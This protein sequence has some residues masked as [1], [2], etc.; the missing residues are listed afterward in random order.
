MTINGAKSG[1]R[2]PYGAAQLTIDQNNKFRRVAAKQLSARGIYLDIGGPFAS[3]TWAISNPRR[4]DV[5]W[6][7]TEKYHGYAHPHL[8]F[9]DWANKITNGTMTT[10][11]TGSLVT[12]SQLLGYGATGI[13]RTLPT[14]PEMSISTSI[15]ELTEGL[16]S[17]IG[18]QLKRGPSAHAVGG[19]Y[20]NYQ[21]GIAPMIS[22]V[23]D[24]LRLSK[25]YQK[26]IEQ[27]RRDNGRLVRRGCVL[28]DTSSTSVSTATNIYGYMGGGKYPLQTMG[29]TSKLTTEVK[30]STKVWF[31]GAYKLAYPLALDG[32]LK[33][34]TEFNRV[35]GVIPTAETAWNLVPFSWLADWFT[36]VGDVVKNAS[37]LGTNNLQ[38]AYGYVMAEDA[39]VYRQYGDYL[40]TYLYDRPR[41]KP[42]TLDSSFTYRRK[43]RLKATPF[44]F[45][46]AFKDLSGSQKAIL[47]ALGL[48]RLRM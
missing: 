47:T 25:S 29:Y 34:I 1:F 12:D 6:S 46:V 17:I 36:N 4:V 35:Y 11:R 43:R 8:Q 31:S 19:E 18:S 23:Q 16:P 13:A 38:L 14:A 39:R 45:S 33:D 27:F 3:E 9:G 48:S 20:L 32:A 22:D 2:T 21:F 28:A 30:D 5:D 15:A 37:T 44:G 26:I 7:A 42:V 10:G 41:N 24:I 40:P